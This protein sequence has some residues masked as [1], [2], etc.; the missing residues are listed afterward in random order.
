MEIQIQQNQ[1]VILCAGNPG[2]NGRPGPPGNPGNPGGRGPPG[3]PGPQGPAGTP[4]T[5]GTGGGKDLTGTQW[6]SW[7]WP[8]RRKCRPVGNTFVT[9]CI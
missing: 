7:E 5:G 1:R 8:C 2:S 6:S 3:P 9:G 4:G